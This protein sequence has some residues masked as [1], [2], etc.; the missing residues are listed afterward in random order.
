M[1]VASYFPV[2]KNLESLGAVN[3][4]PYVAGDGHTGGT[5]DSFDV[6]LF[7][8]E[9]TVSGSQGAFDTTMHV[10]GAARLEIPAPC[11]RMGDDTGVHVDRGYRWRHRVWRTCVQRIDRAVGGRNLL[12]SNRGEFSILS[13]IGILIATGSRPIKIRYRAVLTFAPKLV[14]KRADLA[15][16]CVNLTVPA[17]DHA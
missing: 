6:S 12:G 8:N 3:R 16:E 9:D 1:N 17:K 7:C 11:R 13:E 5:N 10:K 4:T 15:L 14:T 2:R